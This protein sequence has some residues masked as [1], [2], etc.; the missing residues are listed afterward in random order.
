M[1]IFTYGLP[2]DPRRYYVGTLPDRL[3]N[4]YAANV[5]PDY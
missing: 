1:Y 3:H 4:N 5:T 2:K